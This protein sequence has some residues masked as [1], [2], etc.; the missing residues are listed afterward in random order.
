[1][2]KY[3]AVVPVRAGS[4][5][6]RNK[7]I[8]PFAGTTLLQHK[9]AQLQQ[10]SEIEK[11][12]VSSDSD[13][14]LAMAAEA[15]VETHKRASEYCDE[16]TRSFG[17]VVAHVCSS[18]E[19]ENIVWATCTSPLVFPIHYK[20]A[21]AAYEI[22]LKNGYDSLIS[23]ERFQRYLWDDNGPVNY[24]LGLNHVPSQQL[25]PLYFVTDG[26]LIAPRVKMIEWN[27]FH[28][29]NPYRFILAKRNSV[30]VDDALDL[31]CAE[32]WLTMDDQNNGTLPF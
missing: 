15:G 19:G 28:G 6:M 18:V 5:R 24:E 22:A 23:M 20:T 7:N 31:A 21:I 2:T 17:E 8:A 16:K 3:T 12:V 27:Y 13:L 9:I 14:M 32:V 4:T 1:M 25:P 29:V 11:I 26:I 30:D 10:V